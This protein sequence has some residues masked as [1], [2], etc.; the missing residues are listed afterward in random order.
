M[1]PFPI[2]S[3]IC[4]MLAPTSCQNLSSSC[5]LQLLE[6]SSSLEFEEHCALGPFRVETWG[7][8]KAVT[9]SL[10]P[11]AFILFFTKSGKAEKS[12]HCFLL[13]LLW[14]NAPQWHLTGKGFAWLPVLNVWLSSAGKTCQ[15]ELS[16]WQCGLAIWLLHIL[17]TQDT[18]TVTP[19]PMSAGLAL[20]P[21]VYSPSQTA[22]LVR[23]QMFNTSWTYRGLSTFKA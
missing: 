6:F 11:T 1:C 17:V 10:G 20:P 9:Y 15:V 8:A 14:L 4:S 19:W 5:P 7:N 21:K 13:S 3:L 23:G 16:F 12:M 22:P 2:I 18:E